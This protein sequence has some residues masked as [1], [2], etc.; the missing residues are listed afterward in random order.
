MQPNH[1]DDTWQQ[2]SAQ[3]SKAPHAV[4]PETPD[5][6]PVVSMSADIETPAPLDPVPPVQEASSVPDN[7][8]QPVRWQ[9]KEYIHH[10]RNTLWFIVFGV[11]VVG[12]MAL[13]IFL[14]DSISFAILVPVM[15]AALLVYINR[16]P[17]VLDY[18]IGRQGIHIND[19]L[20]SFSEFKGFGVIRDGEEYSVMLIPTK[21]FRPGVV[22]YFPE[23]SGEAIVDMLGA[24]LPMQTLHL[25]IVDTVLRKL[26]I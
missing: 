13:A 7:S 10:E 14:M 12:L 5:A 3:D 22:I 1:D 4:P 9:A 17:R 18:T 11:I 26:R 16:P 23:D 24:R 25:D 19:N 8:D 6:F 2:P 15:A 21:R 20:Y